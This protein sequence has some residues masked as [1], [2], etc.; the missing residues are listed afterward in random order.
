MSQLF[1]RFRIV[2]CS[3]IVFAE[4]VNS[5]CVATDFFVA[6][7]G[8]N[9]KEQNQA[10]MEENILFFHKVIKER[11]PKAWHLATFFSDGIDPSADLQ[12][13][14]P[15]DSELS[16]RDLLSKLHRRGGIP[17]QS[18][19]YRNHRIENLAGSTDPERIHATISEIARR[20]QKG[21]RLFLYVTTHGQAGKKGNPQNTTIAC[22]KNQSISVQQW[23]EW[24]NEIPK[25]IP[26]IQ[27]MTQCYAGGFANTIFTELEA[28]NE[29]AEHPRVGFFAQQFDL[30]AAGCRPDIE[31]DEE[32]SSYFWGALYGKSRNGEPIENVDF[33][34]DGTV[35]FDEAYT[36]AV[37]AGETIDVPLRTSDVFLKQFSTIPNHTPTRER[38]P[39]RAPFRADEST[40]ISKP[41]ESAE[42]HEGALSARREGLVEMSG[43]IDVLTA[44][45]EPLAKHRIVQLCRNVGLSATDTIES[46]DEAYRLHLV[47]IRP[48]G[49]ATRAPGRSGS[50]RR[51]LLEEIGKNWPELANSATWQESPLLSQDRQKDIYQEIIG[52]SSFENYEQRRQD[53][54]A[55]IRKSNL[56]E[57]KTVQFR[58]LYECLE[59]LVLER[60]LSKVATPALVFR[61]QKIRDLEI[62]SL[63][64]P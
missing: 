40:D 2:V 57:L 45:C 56:H 10:S 55:W 46:L 15:K 16:L 21:D 64:R 20:I 32:F 28:R 60:N 13:L 7:G 18:V 5:T 6:I 47:S 53:R 38:F 35:C 23:S 49:G 36:Y 1:S 3:L 24:L 48:G 61:Y 63:A 41:R 39:R 30:Q 27:I 43:S 25:D 17:L 9:V 50:G 19:V 54:E 31:H 22:W 62:S 58:R 52:L 8:G 33:D 37:I 12:V 34:N 29:I 4:Y 14:A 11:S 26:V 59:S 44:F 42:A 51:E